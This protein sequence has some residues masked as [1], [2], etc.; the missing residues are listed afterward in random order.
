MVIV[1]IYVISDNYPTQGLNQGLLHCRQILYQLS[2]KR[3]PVCVYYHPICIFV[4][5]YKSKH[6]YS[7]A[8][9]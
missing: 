5:I 8:I 9:C 7:Y 2:H 1:K 3:S 4:C 6:T